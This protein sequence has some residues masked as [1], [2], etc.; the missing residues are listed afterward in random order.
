MVTAAGKALR[1]A[2]RPYSEFVGGDG[3]R[4]DAIKTLAQERHCCHTT[5]RLAASARQPDGMHGQWSLAAHNGGGLATG[6][7]RHVAHHVYIRSGCHQAGRQVAT[8]RPDAAGRR[9]IIVGVVAEEG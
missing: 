4:A 1:T 7:R 2:A 5:Q 3:I 6:R 9:Y 8:D